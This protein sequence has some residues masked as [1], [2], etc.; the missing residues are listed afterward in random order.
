MFE[1]K[2]ESRNVKSNNKRRF[3][4]LPDDGIIRIEHAEFEST[5]NEVLSTV[6]ER[7][8]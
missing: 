3:P 8:N 7:G 1:Q 2:E 4:D 6:E 5:M